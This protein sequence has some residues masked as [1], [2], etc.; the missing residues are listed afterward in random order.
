MS[1]EC[2][3]CGNVLWY[4]EEEEICPVCDRD[5]VIT[6]LTEAL[7]YILRRGYTGASHVAMEALTK[8]KREKG[9]SCD[10]GK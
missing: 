3:K 10:K 8:I 1:T 5:E 2:K 6:I 4:K 9:A 7:E